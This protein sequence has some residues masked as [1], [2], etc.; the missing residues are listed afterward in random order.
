MKSF[1]DFYTK[2]Q[3]INEENMQNPVD[4][5]VV[6]NKPDMGDMSMPPISPEAP[7]QNDVPKLTDKSKEGDA[8]SE[9]DSNLSPPEGKINYK[10]INKSLKHVSKFLPK[11]K[12]LDEEKGQ[13]LEQL[14]SQLNNLI[15]SFEGGLGEQP[16]EEGGEE[17]AMPESPEQGPPADLSPM[18]GDT[19]STPDMSAG[20]GDMGAGMA[21]EQSPIPQ[22]M[23]PPA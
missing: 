1:Y 21:G 20:M 15:N 3:K 6:D 7:A 10:Y 8:S 18:V 5:K 11:F 14:L 2:L 13:Q 9:E 23:N 12:N 16:E 17:S 22:G 4:P 19:G